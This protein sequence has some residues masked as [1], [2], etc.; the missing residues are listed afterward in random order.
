MVHK[1]VAIKNAKAHKNPH[2]DSIKPGARKAAGNSNSNASSGGI[3]NP[4]QWNIV[5]TEKRVQKILK[6]E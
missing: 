2:L 6:L 5:T 3:G 4:R 1:K